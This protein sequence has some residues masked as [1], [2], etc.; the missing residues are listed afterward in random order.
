MGRRVEEKRHP[1]Q[2]IMFRAVRESD[3]G[4][5]EFVG[6]WRRTEAAAKS[7]FDREAL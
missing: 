7:D 4:G 5:V 6:P 2:G 3:D 1:M